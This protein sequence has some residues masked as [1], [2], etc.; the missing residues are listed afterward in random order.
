LSSQGTVV[1][2]FSIA[3]IKV[4]GGGVKSVFFGKCS[5]LIFG[6]IANVHSGEVESL[7]RFV[8]GTNCFSGFK[9]VVHGDEGVPGALSNI[10][11][12]V[13]QVL[14]AVSA[15]SATS[16]ILAGRVGCETVVEGGSE[17]SISVAT[18]CIA[19]SPSRVGKAESHGFSSG[20]NSLGEV[21]ELK[22]KPFGTPVSTVPSTQTPA[23][24]N[25]PLLL[26]MPKPP[27][28][29]WLDSS[30][31][32]M[33]PTSLPESPEIF[34][35]NMPQLHSDTSPRLLEPLENP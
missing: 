9:A 3:I 13:D 1:V 32:T 19:W 8:L 5:D 35:P 4:D 31:A 14:R 28:I 20:S 10:K 2:L 25:L 23:L 16:F 24:V 12:G 34:V 27:G 33:P 15:I 17:V 21:S 30:T 11:N 6:V 7:F 26:L 29:T 22:L 18:E